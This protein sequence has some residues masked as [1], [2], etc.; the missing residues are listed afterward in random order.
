[1]EECKPFYSL[2]TAGKH[3]DSQNPLQP[4]LEDALKNKETTAG[5]EWNRTVRMTW[6]LN[7][8]VTIAFVARL[9][10]PLSNLY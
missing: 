8:A 1:M 3:F 9:M 10:D 4:R 5:K 2:A 7:V 6:S